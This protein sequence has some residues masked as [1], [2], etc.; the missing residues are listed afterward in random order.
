MRVSATVIAKPIETQPGPRTAR[1]TPRC[2]KLPMTPACP[3]HRAEAGED[4]RF[5]NRFCARAACRR[6]IRGRYERIHQDGQYIKD[7]DILAARFVNQGREFVAVRYLGPM[8]RPL[9][10]A[11]R[12]QHAEGVSARAAGIPARQLRLL[13]RRGCTPSSIPSARIRAPITPHRRARRCMRRA[14]DASAFAA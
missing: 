9:L 13:T 7:G 1:S 6:S 2:S 8:D 14:P 4:I 5:G 10:L 11:R 12:P 3:T